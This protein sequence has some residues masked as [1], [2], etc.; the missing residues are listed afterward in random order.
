MGVCWRQRRVW[1]WLGSMICVGTIWDSV[2]ATYFFH[3]YMLCHHYIII[4]DCISL[5]II[6]IIILY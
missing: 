6:I 3:L 5:I 4:K 1:A 2:Y